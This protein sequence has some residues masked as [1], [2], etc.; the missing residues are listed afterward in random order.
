MK[1]LI[2]LMITLLLLV[3]PAL[4]ELWYTDD[5]L[6]DGSPIYYFEDLSLTLPADWAGKVTVATGENGVTFYQKASYER[7]GEEGQGGDGFLFMLGASVNSS[8]SKL[9]AFVYLGFSERSAMNY[10]LQLP[11]DYRADVDDEAVRAEYDAMLARVEDAVAA[12][13]EFYDAPA[14]DAVEELI[15]DA[16]GADTFDDA[17]EAAPEAGEADGGPTLEQARYFFEHSVLPRYFYEVPQEML[18]TLGDV[19]VYQLWKAIADENGVLYTYQADDYWQRWF[20]AD[21]GT[22]MLQIGMPQPDGNTLC[23][24]VYMA[25]NTQTGTAGYYTVESDTFSPETAFICGWD[26]AG[27]HYNYGGM[28]VLD[29]EAADYEEQLLNEVQIIAEVAGISAAFTER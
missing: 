25:Y 13:A 10:Y 1:R 24:R 19:G 28:D 12:G 18:E 5:I 3:M 9:P 27:T 15:E 21:D 23:Y 16:D 29:P 22:V 8:F 14:E 7:S 11:T 17:E 6:S 26:A 20:D 2:A 4:A